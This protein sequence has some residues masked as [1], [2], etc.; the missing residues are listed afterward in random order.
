MDAF[1]YSLK[2]AFFRDKTVVLSASQDPSGCRFLTYG[3]KAHTTTQSYWNALKKILGPM[4]SALNV[5]GAKAANTSA[6]TAVGNR[7]RGGGT[8]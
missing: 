1:A 8:R 7:W 3:G 2:L 5:N 4:G 6:A